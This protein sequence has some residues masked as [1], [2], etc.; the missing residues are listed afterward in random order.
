[1]SDN[2]DILKIYE[3]YGYNDEDLPDSA[4]PIR[5]HDIDKAHK[6]DDKLNQKLVSHKYYTLDNLSFFIFFLL[7]RIP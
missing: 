4:Y 5:Y 6:I 2:Q 3:L 1:M 7:I